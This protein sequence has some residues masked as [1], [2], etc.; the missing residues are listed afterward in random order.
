MK[1][2]KLWLI[3]VVIGVVAVVS[4]FV[5]SIINSQNS[6]NYYKIYTDIS[7]LEKLNPYIT[8][9]LDTGCDANLKRIKPLESWTNE[10][11]YGGCNYVIY[12]YVFE[13]LTDA[14][15]YYHNIEGLPPKGNHTYHM[16]SNYL[17]TKYYCYYGQFAYYV[18]GENEK[19]FSSFM[20][21]MTEDYSIDFMELLHEAYQ[22]IG[23]E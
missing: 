4:Y 13:N 7:D 12:A 3:F 20:A 14:Q 22:T 16:A 1:K 10:V 11:Q 17:K 15:T 5:V 9:E 23:S 19:D 21:F 8:K 2:N 6:P 18:A